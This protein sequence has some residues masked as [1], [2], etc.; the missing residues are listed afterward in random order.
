MFV[1]LSSFVAS[2]V[3]DK[4]LPYNPTNLRFHQTCR[5]MSSIGIIWVLKY[6]PYIP[7]MSGVNVGG[8][9]KYCKS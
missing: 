5:N 9:I 6:L 1:N 2:F 3:R 8:G 7:I 4:L